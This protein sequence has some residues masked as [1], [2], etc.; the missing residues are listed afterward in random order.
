MLSVD[1]RARAVC[2]DVGVDLECE[3]KHRGSGSKTEEITLRREG[4]HLLAVDVHLHVFHQLHR[5]TLGS[6]EDIADVGHPLV[7]VVALHP[8]ISPVGCETLL[9][10]EVHAAGAE[11]HLHPFRSG[12][13]HGGVQTLVAVAFRYRDPVLHTCGIGSIHIRHDGISQ[14]AVAFLALLRCVDDDA[15]GEEVV[16]ALEIHLLLLH[17]VPD[18]GD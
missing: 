12:T 6:L 15:D 18:G 16:D 5:S 2:A 10:H 8:L 9:C 11:L 7:C 13:H 1:H 14:P 4:K 17:L 3:I